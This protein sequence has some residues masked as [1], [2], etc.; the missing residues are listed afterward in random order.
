MYEGW[1]I[2]ALG[3]IELTVMFDTCTHPRSEDIVFD[4]V[5]IPYP[6][7]AI[8]GRCLLNA[9]YAIPHHGFLCMKMLSP[10]GTIKVLG[11]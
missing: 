3:Q 6:Y 8:F 9:F 1:A 7:N 4:V 2:K 10:K 5:D 11:D